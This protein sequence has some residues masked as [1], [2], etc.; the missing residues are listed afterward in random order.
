[1]A[2]GQRRVV[3][4][5]S[6]REPH[7]P[8]HATARKPVSQVIDPETVAAAETQ[9]AAPSAEVIVAGGAD[10][11]T[12]RT[13]YALLPPTGLAG[14]SDDKLAT[15]ITI[16]AALKAQG[17]SRA[18]IAKATGLSLSAVAWTLRRARE[19]KLLADG[20][21]EAVQELDQEAV[22]LAVEGLLRLLRKADKDAVFKTLD[23]RGLF[24]THAAKD[25]GGGPA[26]LPQLHINIL[27]APA[28]F[29]P[30]QMTGTIHGTPR[31]D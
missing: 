23:G 10:P 20:M 9:I 6:R 4:A 19:R 5:G 21:V 17:Y 29:D 31:E 26:A 15:R 12:D 28:H 2:D 8:T 18:Q 30:S 13:P 25:D 16:V 11:V 3:V 1:M 27:N 14:L 24:K 7:P 22:P